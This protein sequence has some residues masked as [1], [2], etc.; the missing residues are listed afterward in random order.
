MDKNI[1]NCKTHFE[2]ARL[3][4][5]LPSY[6][7]FMY[8]L[9][10]EERK[11]VGTMNVKLSKIKKGKVKSGKPIYRIVKS[12]RV[13]YQ[14]EEE[15]RKKLN[16]PRR[17]WKAPLYSFAVSG[18]WRK[19]THPWWK[20]HGPN[21]EEIIGKTW[22]TEYTKGKNYN[23]LE[24]YETVNKDPN[25]VI[26][27]KQKL[28]YARDVIKAQESQKTIDEKLSIKG[29]TYLPENEKPSD[30]WM[31]D[32]RRK[33]TAGLRFI[34][35]QRDNFK[36]KLCGAS[37]VESKVRLEVDHIIPISKWGR[38]EELNLQT[39]CRECNIGKRD[40]IINLHRNS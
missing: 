29:F 12:I 9:V 23:N 33:L 21:R 11:K 14:A 15:T 30:L 38:T 10:L 17:S 27:L 28:S 2:V 18:H 37:G 4:L 26:K 8:D 25:V 36:C 13:S 19:L 24:Q 39:I 40:Q 7:N 6:F 34:I 22:I 20:G 35:F 31:Y 3:M 5:H 16:T 32:E 1:N